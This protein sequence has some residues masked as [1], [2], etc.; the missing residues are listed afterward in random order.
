MYVYVN[1]LASSKRR[2]YM[3]REKP[4]WDGIYYEKKV[5]EKAWDRRRLN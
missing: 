1:Q 3:L 4:A 5:K 2:R